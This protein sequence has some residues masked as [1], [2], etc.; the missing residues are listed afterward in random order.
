MECFKWFTRGTTPLKI[1]IFIIFLL[2]IIF[3]G[4][5][6]FTFEFY[7]FPHNDS[8]F[9]NNCHL[10][11]KA[12]TK[13]EKSEHKNVNCNECHQLSSGEQNR[14]LLSYIFN[15]YKSVPE[16]HGKIIV[17]W[18]LCM[19]CHW[20][21]DKRFPKAEMINRSRIHGKHVFM[22]RIQCSKCHGYRV[23]EFTPE[24]KFCSNCHT[25]KKVHGGEMEG[26]ACLNCHTDKTVDLRP[27]RNKC[28]FCH[29]EERIRKALEAEGLHEIKHYKPSEQIIKKAVKVN[30]PLKGSMHFDCYKCHKPHT[31]IRPDNKTC[32][33]CHAQI[34]NIRNHKLHVQKM[35]FNCSNCHKP[36]SW[37]VT[38]AI[39]KTTCSRC[40]K[41]K[42]PMDFMNH[43]EHNELKK[44]QQIATQ[45]TSKTKIKEKVIKLNDKLDINKKIKIDYSTVKALYIKKCGACHKI[46]SPKKYNEKE[47]TNQVKRWSK[48]ANLTS[49]EEKNIVTLWEKWVD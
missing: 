44:L 17:P 23:H 28:L 46:H 21:E 39:A 26:L 36:H 41:Y 27:N 42:N 19:K 32:I 4:G 12:Y 14:L 20:E 13:W 8:K 7:E 29:G 34:V 5:G 18:T 3:L 1:K 30:V 9:C 38:T 22:E 35:G 25:N 47:W 31:K 40:H 15:R 33:S 24:A 45:S 6:W 49:E 43:S 48:P 16:R 10:M 2:L 11:N 37:R